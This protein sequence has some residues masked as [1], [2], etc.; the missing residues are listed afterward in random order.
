MQLILAVARQSHTESAQN[1]ELLI[2]YFLQSTLDMKFIILFTF[3]VVMLYF[4]MLLNMF[5]L[6]SFIT[7]LATKLFFLLKTLAAAAFNCRRID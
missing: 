4:T 5:R 3:G 7:T 6:F 2:I 1:V